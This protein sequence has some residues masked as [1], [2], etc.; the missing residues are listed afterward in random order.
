VSIVVLEIWSPKANPLARTPS[1]NHG[2]HHRLI[3]S[4]T[5][6]KIMGRLI[7]EAKRVVKIVSDP[8]YGSVCGVCGCYEVAG[9]YQVLRDRD[10]GEVSGK[11]GI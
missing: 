3:F 5:E 1:I 2:D 7:R 6:S 4:K 11:L 9:R 8:K 10:V